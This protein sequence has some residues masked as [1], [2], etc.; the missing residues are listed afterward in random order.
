MSV[1]GASVSVG[2]GSGVSVAGSSVF[3]GGGS[4]VS[5]AVGGASAVRVE[6]EIAVVT[7]RGRRVGVDRW[8]V[9][10]E[11]GTAVLDGTGVKKTILVGTPVGVGTNAVTA[12]WVSA[13][14]VL[15]FAIAKSTMFNGSI[16]VLSYFFKSP[17]AKA[18][19]LH[20]SPK[21]STAAARIPNGPAYS[22]IRT[23]IILLINFIYK[24]G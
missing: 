14:D 24:G 19:T 17:V 22:L 13:T 9:G 10:E 1:G 6:D 18:E 5:V 16:V 8:G 3:V 23:L 15:M 12:C 21:P 2:G 20:S 7:G 4:D 11:R